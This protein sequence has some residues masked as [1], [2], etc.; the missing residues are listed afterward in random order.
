[1]K[2]NMFK[3]Y[4]A[5]IICLLTLGIIVIIGSII[6]TAYIIPETV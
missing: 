4:I 5:G 1:M 2:I 6:F 3:F